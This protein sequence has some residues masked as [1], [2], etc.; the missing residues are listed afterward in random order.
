M[1]PWSRSAEVEKPMVLDFGIFVPTVGLVI[2]LL[3]VLCQLVFN[4]LVA[5]RLFQ[6]ATR[7]A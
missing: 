3:S 7:S 2:S 1:Q 5:R 4:L 6:P